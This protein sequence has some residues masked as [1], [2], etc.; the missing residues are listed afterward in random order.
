[1]AEGRD[2]GLDG[3][4]SQTKAWLDVDVNSGAAK[5]SGSRFRTKKEEGRAAA[6]ALRGRRRRGD[7]NGST[8]KK[9]EGRSR[10][11]F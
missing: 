11:F 2:D 10:C 7:D 9:K 6:V 4:D 8:R 1:M 3:N 5:V